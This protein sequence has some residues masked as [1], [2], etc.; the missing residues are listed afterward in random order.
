M[1]KEKV[2][3]FLM[4]MLTAIA[5]IASTAFSSVDSFMTVKPAKPVSV[6]VNE[7]SSMRSYD[8]WILTNAQN[9]YILKDVS[10]NQSYTIVVMEK[11]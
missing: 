8:E 6:I 5:I 4:G 9:G 2:I 11:Y 7:G 10:Q 3:P 1:K